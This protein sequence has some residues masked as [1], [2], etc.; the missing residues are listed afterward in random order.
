M[1]SVGMRLQVYCYNRPGANDVVPRCD[2]CGEELDW[3]EWMAVR[4][5]CLSTCVP[6]LRG[7]HLKHRHPEV[8]ERASKVGKRLLYGAVI[9][10]IIAV[11]GLAVPDYLVTA[12]AVLVASG[13]L[14]V[15]T[16]VRIRTLRT[17]ARWWSEEGPEEE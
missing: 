1:R 4:Y 16:A 5:A 10:A 11:L 15:G 14:A 9:S 13:L 2:V 3:E 8:A 12:G 17:S 6:V 7:S